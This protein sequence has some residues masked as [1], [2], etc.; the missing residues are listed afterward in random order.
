MNDDVGSPCATEGHLQTAVYVWATAPHNQDWLI[1]G[2]SRCPETQGVS[3]LA[4]RYAPSDAIRARVMREAAE[5]RE[6]LALGSYGRATQENGWV[7]ET[8]SADDWMEFVLGL[9]SS[10]T[11]VTGVVVRM[12]DEQ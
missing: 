1:T 7:A 2:C 9:Q 4:F 6:P 3:S 10:N 12:A 5:P 11:P 8:I